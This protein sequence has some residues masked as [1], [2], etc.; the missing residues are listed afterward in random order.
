[1][2]LHLNIPFPG[3]P[4]CCIG[5]KKFASRTLTVI[6]ISWSRHQISNN[7]WDVRFEVFTAVTMKNG[8]FWDV[9]QRGSCKNL[10]LEELSASLI[11][12]NRWTRNVNLTSNR[13]TLNRLS[14]QC[15][16]RNIW[17]PYR[18]PWPVMAIA[19]LFFS[20]LPFLL[21]ILIPPNA[22]KVSSGWNTK[23]L[24]FHIKNNQGMHAQASGRRKTRYSKNF[25]ICFILEF[26]FI[27]DLYQYTQQ[28]V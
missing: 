16:N 12:V 5:N 9:T 26:H 28:I 11:R 21:P 6:Y 25:G 1:L 8:L 19:V 20:L 3:N 2:K 13:R 23:R 7:Y 27:F 15:G 10:I 22:P 14:R 4:K 24:L 18:P 17:Q